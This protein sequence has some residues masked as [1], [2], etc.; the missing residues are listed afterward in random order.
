MRSIP[1][2]LILA[3]SACSVANKTAKH[4]GT[5]FT[6]LDQSAADIHVVPAS[7]TDGDRDYRAELMADLAA[8]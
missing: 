7:G 4:S 3:L 6:E 1:L 5:G 8:E 2:L